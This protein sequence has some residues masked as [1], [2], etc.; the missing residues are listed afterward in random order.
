MPPDAP[1]GLQ[2]WESVIKHVP[3]MYAAVTASVQS[4]RSLDTP[5]AVIGSANTLSCMVDTLMVVTAAQSNP[6][7]QTVWRKII[8]AK[9][10]HSGLK[11]HTLAVISLAAALCSL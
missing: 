10:W 3:K 11:G 5:N 9:V 4:A 2:F 8:K 7:Q 6:L 1:V